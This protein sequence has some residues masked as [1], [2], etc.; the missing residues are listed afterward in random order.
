M[1]NIQDV[2]LMAGAIF[3]L[4]SVGCVTAKLLRHV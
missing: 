3:C 2:L 4:I 1:M